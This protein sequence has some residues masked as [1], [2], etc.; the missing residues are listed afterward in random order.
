MPVSIEAFMGTLPFARHAVAAPQL[1]PQSGACVDGDAERLFA[2]MLLGRPD[3]DGHVLPDTVIA[4]SGVE[5]AVRSLMPA[6]Y[7]CE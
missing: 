6:E 7:P 2:G 4:P 1:H 3:P 5:Y